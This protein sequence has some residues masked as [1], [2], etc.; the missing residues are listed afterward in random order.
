MTSF[1]QQK[2]ESLHLPFVHPKAMSHSEQNYRL[3]NSAFLVYT[4]RIQ[5]A[6]ASL[7]H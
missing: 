7:E 4:V 6:Y 1:D 3:P 2:K 5:A